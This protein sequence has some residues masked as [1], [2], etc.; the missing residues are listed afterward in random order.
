MD[1]IDKAGC[2]MIASEIEKA[3]QGVLDKHNLSVCYESGRWTEGHA[4]LKF[5]VKLTAPAPGVLTPVERAYDRAQGSSEIYD[6][7]STLPKRN[8]IIKYP[9]TGESF[10]IVGW[11]NRARKFP[12][13]AIKEGNGREYTLSEQQVSLCNW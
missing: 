9:A 5:E 13:I 2:R 1:R 8:T 11:N 10:K 12:I 3:A 7:K 6:H 4:M